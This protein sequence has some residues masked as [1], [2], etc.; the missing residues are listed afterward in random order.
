MSGSSQATWLVTFGLLG[1][2]LLFIFTR[3]RGF[4]AAPLASA[5]MRRVVSWYLPAL[6]AALVGCLVGI[7]V[8]AQPGQALERGVTSGPVLTLIALAV[9]LSLVIAVL[10]PVLGFTLGERLKRRGQIEAASSVTARAFLALL[11]G[12]VGVLITMF[13]AFALTN[14]APGG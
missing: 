3:A 8:L 11:A 14:P 9:L 5:R 13:A 6:V 7:P 12:G 10:V 4:A 2:V 1:V